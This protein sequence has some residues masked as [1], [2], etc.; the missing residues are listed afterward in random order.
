MIGKDLSHAPVFYV[1]HRACTSSHEVQRACLTGHDQRE[2]ATLDVCGLLQV[3]L[4]GQNCTLSKGSS[5]ASASAPA[6]LTGGS[7]GGAESV[8][9]SVISLSSN[10]LTGTTAL[11]A[12]SN[13][14]NSR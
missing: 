12:I 6:S 2:D 10:T 5:A 11:A 13:D 1:L 9:S 7:I 8:E 3:Q 4:N 14:G